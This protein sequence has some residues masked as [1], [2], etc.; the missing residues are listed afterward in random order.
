MSGLFI[1]FEGGDG[2]GKTTQIAR[3]AV[4]L[5]AAGREVVTLR[6]PGCTMV[7]EGV[8]DILLNPA[9]EVLSPIAE[10]LLFAAGRAELSSSIIGPTLDAGTIVL[11]DRYADSSL[12]YQGYGRGL[13][14]AMIRSINAIATG[15]L[16]P[17]RTIVLDVE[18][19]AGIA[20]ATPHTA[21]RLEREDIAFHERIRD[22]YLAMAA[23]EPERIAVVGRDHADIVWEGVLAALADTFAAVGIV[24]EA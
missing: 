2:S 19:R 23:E 16:V 20:A 3:L 6:E 17:D 7:G 1:T 11:C 22:G 21:D 18:P 13:D 4:V 10:F 5:R 24:V 9:K 15:G 8:R 12:A 14:L